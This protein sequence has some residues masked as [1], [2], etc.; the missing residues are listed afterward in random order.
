MAGFKKSSSLSRKSSYKSLYVNPLTELKHNRSNS[1]G[2]T[3][4]I[5]LCRNRAVCIGGKENE[6]PDSCSS[7]LKPKPLSE[8]KPTSSSLHH[9]QSRVLKPS[10]LQLCMQKNEP[11]SAF[12]SSL[13][14]DEK[15][16]PPN[17]WDFSDSE[18]APA[19]SWS[20]LPNRSVCDCVCVCVCFVGCVISVR[21]TG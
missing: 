1:D 7:L 20:T 6:T 13:L 17:A 9:L 21:I 12:G 18:A 11:D 14:G 16:N 2:G 19:S 5:H 3:L 4:G 8:R 10:S 15:S